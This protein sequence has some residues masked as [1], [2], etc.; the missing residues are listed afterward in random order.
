MDILYF[1][2]VG[3]GGVIGVFGAIA[4]MMTVFGDK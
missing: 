1:G 3:A 4:A 2:G